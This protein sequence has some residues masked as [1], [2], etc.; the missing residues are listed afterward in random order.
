M[1]WGGVGGVVGGAES[2]H[3]SEPE[4]VTATKLFTA[5]FCTNLLC[6][7][8]MTSVQVYSGLARRAVMQQWR[9]DV[10]EYV[11]ILKKYFSV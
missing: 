3:D 10:L 4:F 6:V 1:P 5:Q 8:V 7:V 11:M 9:C 2:T